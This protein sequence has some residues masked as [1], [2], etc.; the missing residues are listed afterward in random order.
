MWEVTAHNFHGFSGDV[1]RWAPHWLRSHG[2]PGYYS[3]ERWAAT[4]CA[5]LSVARALLSFDAAKALGEKL[6]PY[7]QAVSIRHHEYDGRSP[8]GRGEPAVVWLR[9]KS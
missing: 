7:C 4:P 2:G 1:P 6:L 3:C 5:A 8:R 9:R